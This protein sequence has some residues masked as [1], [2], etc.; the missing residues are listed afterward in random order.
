M[1][2]SNLQEF[3]EFVLH[4]CQRPAM[5]GVSSVEGLRLLIFGIEMSQEGND[6]RDFM[7]RFKL[8]VESKLEMDGFS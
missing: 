6:V 5:Y 4:V 1:A 8:A 3:K 7:N 2:I